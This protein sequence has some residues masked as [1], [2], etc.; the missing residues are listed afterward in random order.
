LAWHSNK[1]KQQRCVEIVSKHTIIS[2]SWSSTAYNNIC[3]EKERRPFKIHQ[4]KWVLDPSKEEEEKAPLVLSPRAG[5]VLEDAWK[6]DPKSIA[7]LQEVLKGK[8]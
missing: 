1:E 2:K 8:A 7:S 3:R 5:I 6:V 4:A